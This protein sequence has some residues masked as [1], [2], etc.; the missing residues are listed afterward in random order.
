MRLSHR[1]FFDFLSNLCSSQGY[2]AEGNKISRK[3]VK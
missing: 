1:D 2:K 3:E